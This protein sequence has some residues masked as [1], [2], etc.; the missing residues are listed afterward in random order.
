MARPD[1]AADA[2][3]IAAVIRDLGRAPASFR[4]FLRLAS[5]NWAEGVLEITTPDGKR[6]DIEG[7]AEGPRGALIVH[8][9]G[10]VRRIFSGGDVGFAE[11]W[12]AGE[13]DTPDLSKLLTVL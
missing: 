4:A 2:A 7:A 12:M 3:C 8:N 13:W 11:G 5:K 10:F 6:V 9:Y 1:Q